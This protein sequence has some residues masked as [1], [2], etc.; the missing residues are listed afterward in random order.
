MK[1]IVQLTKDEYQ[2]ISDLAKLNEKQINDKA[3][4]LYK[5]KGFYEMQ[6]KL[7]F[8]SNYFGHLTFKP[9]TYISD[10]NKFELKVEDKRKI[11][12][13][14]QEKIKRFFEINFGKHLVK[15]NNIAKIEEDLKR[16]TSLLKGFYL[17]GWLMALVMFL[18][19]ILK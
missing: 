5:K 10:C 19:I 13:F 11:V 17:L 9:K 15:L 8:K 16:R 2:E 12:K 3:E 18:F 6:I 1:E 14:T 7:E 4:K